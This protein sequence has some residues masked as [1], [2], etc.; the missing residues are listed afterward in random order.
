MARVGVII[1]FLTLQL[2]PILFTSPPKPKI[3]LPASMESFNIVSTAAA[4]RAIST[5]SDLEHVLDAA[6]GN[7]K[8]A[9]TPLNLMGDST[10]N[11]SKGCR[12]LAPISV[13][14]SSPMHHDS[15]ISHACGS[16][17]VCALFPHPT[18]RK[19]HRSM[20]PTR[21]MMGVLTPRKVTIRCN[22]VINND[23]GDDN[24]P[25]MRHDGRVD[26]N[27]GGARI[28]YTQE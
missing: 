3:F 19:E 6:K 14:Q 20:T 10:S 15:L 25:L 23:S 21:P 4:T 22:M 2:I 13:P 7:P 9:D 18:I 26:L 17:P 1:S 8:G 24:L 12:H 28:R 16:H 5:A 11:T 27:S